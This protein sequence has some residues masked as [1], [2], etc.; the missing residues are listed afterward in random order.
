[1]FSANVDSFSAVECN[2]LAVTIVAQPNRSEIVTT[3][4]HSPE[5]TR[6]EDGTSRTITVENTNAGQL[7]VEIRVES[8]AFGEDGVEVAGPSRDLAVFPA[9]AGCQTR[10]SGEMS[11]SSR[12]GKFVANPP[13]SMTSCPTRVDC[14]SS[15]PTWRQLPGAG[16][17]PSA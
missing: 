2:V 8:L 9:Q 4:D 1:M 15:T 17:S 6:T 16:V 5:E 11:I 10:P 7:P 14:S 12:T 13:S 3:I